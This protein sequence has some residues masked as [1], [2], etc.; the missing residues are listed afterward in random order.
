MIGIHEPHLIKK[1]LEY[2]KSAIKSGWVSTSGNL[3]NKFEKKLS[4]FLKIKYVLCTNSGTSALSLAIKILKPRKNEEVIISTINFISP[5]NSI[6]YNNCN[7]IFLDCDDSLNLD[8]D[9]VIDFLKKKTFSKRKG[10]KIITYNK[11]SQKKIIA[12]IVTHVFGNPARIDRLVKFC[13]NKNIKII[14]DC[15]ESIGSKFNYNK[16]KK[17]LTG[18]VGDISCFSFNGNKIITSGSG[19]ALCT[20][21]K[22]L[23]NYSKFL[24][25]QSKTDRINFIHNE[26]GYNYRMSNLQAALG[27][28]QF[29]RLKLFLKKKKKILEWYTKYLNKDKFTLLNKKNSSGNNWLFVIEMKILKKNFKNIYNFF[30]KNKIQLRPVW[31]PNHMQK[32]LKKYEKYNIK[33]AYMFKKY[34]CLPSS[35]FLKEQDIKKI[36][37]LLNFYL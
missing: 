19:G 23:Y 7:P 24:S 18:T 12:I 29:K 16:S 6:L 10:D 27:L 8:Q 2:I 33:N 34:L 14:E 13:K 31:F 35:T 25:D 17:K 20:N 15:A 22:A 21:N 26:L 11:R 37:N 1:D 32:F 28:A 3:I 9:K 36:S 5:V 30:Y 4:N